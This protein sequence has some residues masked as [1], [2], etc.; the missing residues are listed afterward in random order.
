MAALLPME[1]KLVEELP[2]GEGWQYEPKWDGFRAIV[3]KAGGDVAIMSKS[4]KPLARYFPEVVA[5]VSA[6]NGDVTL[7]GEL[8]LP[9]GDTLSFDALQ[10]R[11]HPAASRIERLSRETPAQLMLFDCLSLG[12][13]DLTKQPLSD[14]RAALER[15]HAR[16]GRPA[17]LLS[18]ATRSIEEAQAW[19]AKS[20]G[21]LDGV[22]AKR[23]DEP[24]RWG[25]RAMLKVKTHRSAD[26]VVGGFR[27]AKE[28][29]QVA[30]LLLGLYN[31]EGRLD[32]VGFCSGIAAKNRAAL[33]KKLE[34]LIAP[35]GF[36]GKAPGGPSRWNQGRENEWEPL[37]PELV[38]EVLYDQVTAR[39]FRHGTRLL[40]WRPDKAPAQC[41]F[42]QLI[43][44]LRP[45]ELKALL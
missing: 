15:F 30:S 16:E 21:A 32:H 22:V 13:E 3:T 6:I 38:V 12:S 14:R 37:R 29:G 42:D 26:C 11:L 36:D 25:E 45:A 39:R 4:G 18:P 34:A 7:D 23:L 10:Q 1:A 2:A 9:I 8:I 35:P 40:R 19:L 41:R 20:G 43:H 28:G 27:R 24:Y 5:L 44:E 33:T 31:E 17:L